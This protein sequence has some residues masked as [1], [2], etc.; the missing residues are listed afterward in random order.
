MLT[1]FSAGC[2]CVGKGEK[3]KMISQ[4]SAIKIA[5]NDAGGFLG[6]W[7]HAELKKGYWHINASSKSA[8]PPIYYVIDAKSGDIKLKLTNRDEPSQAEL[9]SEFLKNE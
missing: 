8:N 7:V 9:L 1:I 5:T 3:T 6:T 2:S 4:E